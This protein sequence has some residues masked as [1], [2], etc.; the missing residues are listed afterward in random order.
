MDLNNFDNTVSPR[1]DFYQY[2][3]GGWMA[4]H[5]LTPEYARFGMFDLLRENAR[6]QLKDL[7]LNMS[8]NAEAKVPGTIA[9]KVGDLYAMGMD[10]ER[11][12]AE[13]AAPCVR[14]STRLPQPTWKM[15]WQPCWHGNT[16]ASEAVSS[17][18]EWV[19]M[20]WIRT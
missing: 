11:L 3:N 7:I 14:F 5:P 17:A 4:A 18:A 10:V 8:D 6:E 20:P 13:G 15:I 16:Q 1:E 12:N 9:Q 19:R 2:C